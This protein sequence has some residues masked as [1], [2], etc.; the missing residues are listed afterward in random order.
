VRFELCRVFVPMSDWYVRLGVLD[1]SESHSFV[2]KFGVS[3]LVL[4]CTKHMGHNSVVFQ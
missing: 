3:A 1:L 4:K 2:P